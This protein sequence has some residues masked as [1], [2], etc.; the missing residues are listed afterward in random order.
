[1][2][3]SPFK[4]NSLARRI[5]VKSAVNACLWMCLFISLPLFYLAYKTDS[6]DLRIVFLLVA[7]IPVVIFAVSFIYF[8]F[9][10]PDY[11]R[12]EEHQ[13]KM[14]SLKLL[15]DKDNPFGTKADDIVAITNPKLLS[16][17]KKK[18]KKKI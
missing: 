17:P 8:M 2:L 5:S 12:S 16:G 14:E 18:A 13:F 6:N 7:I 9:K 1:M 11:L 10:N 3:H 4:T 15:G